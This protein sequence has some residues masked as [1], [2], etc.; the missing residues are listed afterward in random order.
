MVN[1]NDDMKIKSTISRK[2]SGKV[3]DGIKQWRWIDNSHYIRLNNI[4]L[5]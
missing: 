2:Y 4:A 3:L 5:F 1:D